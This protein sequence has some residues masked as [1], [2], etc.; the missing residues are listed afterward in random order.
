[1]WIWSDE[2]AS[3]HE[4]NWIW[5]AYVGNL[6][7]GSVRIELFRVRCLVY[8]RGLY[9]YVTM[10]EGKNGKAPSKNWILL[11][12]LNYISYS[13]HLNI[14][15]HSSTKSEI[16]IIVWDKTVI[17]EQSWFTWRKNKMQYTRVWPI[18][19]GNGNTPIKF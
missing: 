17:K 6:S 2:G 18:K 8:L 11:W 13:V 7:P 1:M 12:I 9:K 3:F 16:G 15:L 4:W 14:N 19:I 10:V 5:S